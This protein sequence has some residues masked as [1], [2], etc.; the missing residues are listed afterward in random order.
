M[1]QPVAPR[2]QTFTC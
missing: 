2:L 1:V